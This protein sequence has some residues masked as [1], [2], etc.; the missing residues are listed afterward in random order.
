MFRISYIHYD[1]S[2]QHGQY[3]FTAEQ[4]SHWLAYLNTTYPDL[5]HW[6]EE[7]GLN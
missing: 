4:A 7:E 1:G 2:L 5:Q 6:I 3:C